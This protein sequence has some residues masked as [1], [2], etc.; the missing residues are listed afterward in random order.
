MRSLE[1]L[2][3]LYNNNE[4]TASSYLTTNFALLGSLPYVFH[5]IKF[6]FIQN[7]Q[8]RVTISRQALNCH[9]L[10]ILLPSVN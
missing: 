8:D 6:F 5:F 10:N 7:K 1:T 2:S 3:R 9:G 4:A